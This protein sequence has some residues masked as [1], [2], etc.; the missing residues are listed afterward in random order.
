MFTDA[1]GEAH[2]FARVCVW[3]NIDPEEAIR[4]LRDEWR[5]VQLEEIKQAEYHFDRAEKKGG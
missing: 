5:A 1:R 2:E 3:K 4:I